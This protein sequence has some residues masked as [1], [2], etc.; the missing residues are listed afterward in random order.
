MFLILDEFPMVTL[1]TI[2]ESFHRQNLNQGLLKA[3]LNGCQ[4][5]NGQLLMISKLAVRLP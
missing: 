5:C 2:Y 3:P 4:G 1:L